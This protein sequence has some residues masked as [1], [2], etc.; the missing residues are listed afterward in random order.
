MGIGLLLLRAR[1]AM[2]SVAVLWCSLST[3]AEAAAVVGSSGGR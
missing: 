3:G 2:V 1:T